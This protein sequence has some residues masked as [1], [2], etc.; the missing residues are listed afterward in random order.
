M[1][2]YIEIFCKSILKYSAQVYR[3][4]AQ[5]YW[6]I[7]RKYIEI[8]QNSRFNI[9]TGNITWYIEISPK[10]ILKFWGKSKRIFFVKLKSNLL[11]H[12]FRWKY[13]DFTVKKTWKIRYFGGGIS[14]L[15]IALR[16]RF[17][18]RFSAEVTFD[19]PCPN[20]L[21]VFCH[22]K[23]WIIG[24]DYSKKREISQ[25]YSNFQIWPLTTVSL[26]LMMVEDLFHFFHQNL[27]LW[28]SLVNTIF[29]SK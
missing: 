24:V 22:D 19:I 7:R 13:I 18:R 17:R 28:L 10:S 9:R 12:L 29:C 26:G 21:F 4:S 8:L 1:H 15:T 16:I 2:K 6:N 3:N 14:K 23:P 20:E 25:K 11:K 5:L 27:P